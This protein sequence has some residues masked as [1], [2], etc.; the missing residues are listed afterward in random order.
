MR[1]NT[2]T[3]HHLRAVAGTAPQHQAVE[4]P[5]RDIKYER[6]RNA[7]QRRKT[8]KVKHRTRRAA[9]TII[10]TTQQIVS[11]VVAGASRRCSAEVCIMWHCVCFCMC[12]WCLGRGE[13][14]QGWRDVRGTA[15]LPSNTG[16]S[17]WPVESHHCWVCASVCVCL[18]GVNAECWACCFYSLLYMLERTHTMQIAGSTG[19]VIAIVPGVYVPVVRTPP[20]LTSSMV[21]I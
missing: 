10:H 7:E 8:V 19:A 18:G 12:V 16:A 13:V 9:P 5:E 17:R 14:L 4:T 3:W 11:S 1:T 15:G 2:W 21:L 6:K 20:A